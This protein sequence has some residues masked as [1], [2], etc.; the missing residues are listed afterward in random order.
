[1]VFFCVLLHKLFFPSEIPD[2][3]FFTHT[4]HRKHNPKHRQHT[5]IA[6]YRESTHHTQS[7]N[8]IKNSQEKLRIFNHSFASRFRCCCAGCCF[9]L[10]FAALAAL[11]V[12]ALFTKSIDPPP[13]FLVLLLTS[14]L[15][16]LAFCS[17]RSNTAHRK[18]R[19]RNLQVKAV[20]LWHIRHRHLTARQIFRPYVRCF[21]FSP[22]HDESEFRVT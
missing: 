12:T 17:V 16:L 6:P 7:Q 19:N 9:S 18:T 3:S 15:R 14:L 22:L 20:T 2:F 11:T 4:T 13:A 8:K 5:K 1:M 21:D 10:F